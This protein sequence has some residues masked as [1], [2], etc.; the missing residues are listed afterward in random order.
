MRPG[1]GLNHEL[2]GDFLR[3]DRELLERVRQ[4]PGPLPTL[5]FDSKVILHRGRRVEVYFLGRGHTDGDAVVYLPEERIAFLGD[6]LFTKTLPNIRDGYSKEWIETLER[7]LDLGATCF[8]PRHGPVSTVDDVRDEI[9]YL[10]WLRATVE[11]LVRSGKSVE[12][13]KKAV[14]L[15]EKYGG[16]RFASFFPGNLETTRR[17]RTGDKRSS[18]PNL[19]LLRGPA[20]VVGISTCDASR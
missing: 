18:A 1:K 2:E 12:E 4:G 11:P 15:P 5:T 17:S 8:V 20:R 14:T 9:D 7:S 13:V 6:L 19:P 10:R 16:Y 3:L